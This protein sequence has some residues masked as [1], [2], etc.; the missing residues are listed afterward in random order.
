[1]KIAF[2]APVRNCEQYLRKNLEF[3]SSLTSDKEIDAID[4][5]ILENDSID[6]TKSILDEYSSCSNF[7]IFFE[8]NLTQKLTNRIERITYV[9]NKLL[10]EI[11]SSNINYDIYIALDLDLDLFL[12][13]SKSLFINLLKNFSKNNSED[14][15]FPNSKPFY[16]D[17]AALRAPNW[18]ESD[19]W[20]QYAKATKKIKLG[21]IFLRLYFVTRK[22]R[23]ISEKIEKIKVNSAFG[24]IGIYKVD[25]YILSKQ[26]YNISEI[27][28]CEHVQF[29]NAFE[30]KF[31]YP[32]WIIKAP[33][34]HLGFKIL[35]TRNK[36]AY[37]YFEL[38]SEIKKLLKID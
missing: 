15:I 9:R 10:A 26:K 36:I 37:I 18:V 17:L 22:Q 24:G 6:N 34:E 7:H 2:S 16:Y 3:L 1:M 33:T 28:N 20:N 38:R 23:K 21:K 30:N 8:D 14:A 32:N 35:N 4:I 27:D 19:V 12:N 25:K 11:S 5:F 13:T 29:N 31:I